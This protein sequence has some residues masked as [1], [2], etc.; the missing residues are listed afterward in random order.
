M[1]TAT[2]TVT[3]QHILSRKDGPVGHLIFNN[4]ARHNAMSLEMSM[5]AADVMD[6]FLADDAIRVIVLSGAGGK[7]FVSGADISKFEISRATKEQ[8]AE[9]NKKGER[10]RILLKDSPKPTIAMIRGYCIGGGLGVALNC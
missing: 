4:P 10:F 8:I 7:A 3:E 1:N 9:Y 5:A 6:D 2:E